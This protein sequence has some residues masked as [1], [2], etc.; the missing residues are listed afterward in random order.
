[1][2]ILA[3]KMVE[4]VV[5]RICD[6]CNGSVMVEVNNEKY[7]ECG[8]L[9][10]C[11]GYGSKNDGTAYHLDLCE[12]CFTVAL[13]ALKDH[14]RSLVMFDNDHELPNETFGVDADR[15]SGGNNPD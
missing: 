3:E 5:D 15:S 8:E 11:W 6:V 4:T 2:K 9:T 1:M 13:L 10:A 14:R 7:E 12:R